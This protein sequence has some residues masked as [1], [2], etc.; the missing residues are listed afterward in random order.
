MS[1]I[2]ERL[3][4]LYVR[5]MSDFSDS[6]DTHFIPWAAKVKKEIDKQKPVFERI[7][8]DHILPRREERIRDIEIQLAG[9]GRTGG[10]LRNTGVRFANIGYSVRRVEED[11]THP[12]GFSEG[13]RYISFNA[14]G[15]GTTDVVVDAAKNAKKSGVP[16]I[17]FTSYPES[18]LG[19]LSDEMVVIK[20]RT[21]LDI[22]RDTG[23]RKKEPHTYM[24]TEFEFK[25]CIALEQVTSKVAK[26]LDISEEDMRSGHKKDYYNRL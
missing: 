26:E 25:L 2:D 21:K 14:S 22:D 18:P 3:P 11:L 1:N 23:E 10:F 12:L 13:V 17:V 24:G 6:I 7:I 15:S 16:V 4:P 5:N 9:T 20:G 19:I 8:Y